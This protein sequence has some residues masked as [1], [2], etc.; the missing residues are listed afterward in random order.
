MSMQVVYGLIHAVH[1]LQS[2]LSLPI[3]MPAISWT[4]HVC[5]ADGKTANGAGQHKRQTL[6]AL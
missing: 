5:Y 1:Q 4:C 3:F 2:Q 6:C